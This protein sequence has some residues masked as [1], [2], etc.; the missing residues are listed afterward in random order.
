MPVK[1]R[2]RRDDEGPPHGAGHESTRGRQEDPVGRR[3]DRTTGSPPQDGE[4]VAEHHDL[5]LLE[6]VRSI[7][8]RYQLKNASQ[9][10]IRHRNQHA[11]SGYLN[12]GTRAI[13]R[14]RIW[15]H[16]QPAVQ[17]GALRIC[18]PHKVYTGI[19]AVFTAIRA[20]R[21]PRRRDEHG[22]PQESVRQPQLTHGAVLHGRA[23]PL[24]PPRQGGRGLSPAV[25]HQC[26]RESP[27]PVVLEKSIWRLTT[28]SEAWPA[29]QTGLPCAALATSD[30]RC[31]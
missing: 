3:Q 21:E 9:D 29:L 5:E 20:R 18:A 2:R 15:V 27:E 1:E 28:S 11:A 10:E 14:T 31:D 16:S 22:P 25:G 7:P 30:P 12:A 26:E 4:F 17:K 8:E 19:D 13:L 24:A 23:A 6:G